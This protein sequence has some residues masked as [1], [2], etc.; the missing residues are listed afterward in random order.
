MAPILAHNWGD[1][2]SSGSTTFTINE[3]TPTLIPNP[4]AL[5]VKNLPNSATLALSWDLNVQLL[6]QKYEFISAIIAD[7]PLNT[8]NQAPLAIPLAKIKTFKIPRSIK[9]LDTPTVENFI[10]CL[11]VLTII[12]YFEKSWNLK[13]TSSDRR[14]YSPVYAKT[15]LCSGNNTWQ[16]LLMAKS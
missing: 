4:M 16:A 7:V 8:G 2:L 6:F 12:F 9:A 3:A 14:F 1:T 13:M 5:M 10:N 11:K 15:I